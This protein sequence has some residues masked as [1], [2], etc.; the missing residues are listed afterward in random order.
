MTTR[1]RT[2]VMVL[3]IVAVMAGFWFAILA[4]KREDANALAGKIATAKTQLQAAQASVQAGLAAERGYA[5]DYATVARLGKAVPAIDDVPSLVYQLQAAA[6]GSKVGFDSIILSGAG[7]PA[8]AVAATPAAQVAAIGKD[9]KGESATPAPAAAA[10][11]AAATQVAAAVLPPGAAV[12]PAGFPTM[13]FDF[14]FNGSFFRLE[15]FLAKLRGFTSAGGKNVDVRG[16]LL[17]VDGISVTEFPKL[18][19]N[20]HATAYL[21]PDTQGLLAGATPAGPATS[22]ATPVSAG[23][24]STAPPAVATVTGVGR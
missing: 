12:G 24:S 13:P 18:K 8:P 22:T 2:V 21:L 4:P 3:V 9:Q 6:T 5:S 20:I 19:V 10:T 17:T 1:D 15:N 23:S 7:T 16:R 14:V 11:P